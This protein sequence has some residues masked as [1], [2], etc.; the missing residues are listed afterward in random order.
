MEITIGFACS[1]FARSA[2]YRLAD[3]S[4]RMARGDNNIEQG[5]VTYCQS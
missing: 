4:L 1:T 3:S 2:R 5:H